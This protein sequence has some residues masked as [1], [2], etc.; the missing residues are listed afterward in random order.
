MLRVWDWPELSNSGINSIQ[1]I[2][3]GKIKTFA[4]KLSWK[5]INCFK[6]LTFEIYVFS[7]AST[8][9]LIWSP[10]NFWT[11]KLLRARLSKSF[12]DSTLRSS[13]PTTDMEAFSST[14]S[15]SSFNRGILACLSEILMFY[16]QS[17]KIV[18]TIYQIFFILSLGYRL[19]AFLLV[20]IIVIWIPRSLPS[21]RYVFANRV[22]FITFIEEIIS[23]NKRFKLGTNL[24]ALAAFLFRNIL[25]NVDRKRP[26]GENGIFLTVQHTSFSLT[27]RK[28]FSSLFSSRYFSLMKK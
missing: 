26:I 22:C 3:V 23:G 13:W 27:A 10:A 15:E 9:R 1:N 11:S 8:S 6:K 19:W 21:L 24:G 28:H 5:S 2:G 17:I 20:E 12:A 7:S 18:I 16:H 25:E 4:I 14:W